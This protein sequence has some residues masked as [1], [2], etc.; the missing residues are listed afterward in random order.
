[1]TSQ[2][3]PQDPVNWDLS[4]GICLLQTQQFRGWKFPIVAVAFK[5]QC[6]VKS[7]LAASKATSHYWSSY[8]KSESRQRWSEVKKRQMVLR[9]DLFWEQTTNFLMPSG[10]S[11]IRNTG[12]SG[13]G[14]EES[15]TFS[16]Y[17][18]LKSNSEDIRKDLWLSPALWTG[19]V[20]RI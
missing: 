5:I 3:T 7:C 4:S 16:K 17:Q 9:G 20:H 1:M 12:V 8:L 2:L 10:N 11:E 18:L 6:V 13:P 19:A 14:L 15:R